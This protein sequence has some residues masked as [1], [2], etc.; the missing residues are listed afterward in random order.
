MRTSRCTPVSGLQEAVRV[1][2]LD[3]EHRALDTR[4]FALAQ[5][6]DLDREAVALGPA[7]V[8]AH[9]H[10]APSPAPRCRR[11]RRRSRSARRGS[12]R[13][14]AAATAARTRAGLV[15]ERSSLGVEFRRN[16]RIRFDREQFIQLARALQRARRAYRTARPSPSAPSPAGRQRARVPGSPRRRA[17]AICSSRRPCSSRRRAR[18]K[19]PPELLESLAQFAQRTAA[20]RFCHGDHV[21]GCAKS[22]LPAGE[23]ARRRVPD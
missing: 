22:R 15:V 23:T 20:L 6:E 9:E 19:M 18:S 5:V 21:S 8:H 7:R 10:L 16:R 2:A 11:R 13:A 17:S 4:F 14:R 1:L 12:R 3:L